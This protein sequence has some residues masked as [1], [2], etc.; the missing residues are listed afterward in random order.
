ML[1]WRLLCSLLFL[2]VLRKIFT[3][4]RQ[5]AKAI[6]FAPWRL[7]ADISGANSVW[8]GVIRSLSLN[9]SKNMRDNS[10]KFYYGILCLL[11]FSCGKKKDDTLF[12]QLSPAKS[13]IHFSNDIDDS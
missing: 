11:V 7:C 10:M 1:I 3:Q 9:L 2:L 13:G 8:I 5:G 6:F 12:T 4:R